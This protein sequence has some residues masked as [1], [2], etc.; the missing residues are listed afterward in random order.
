MD[1]LFLSVITAF[2]HIVEKNEILTIFDCRLIISEHPN[3]CSK[4]LA[5]LKSIS[6]G[7]TDFSTDSFIK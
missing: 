3:I 6:R 1:P 7:K 2:A 4:I 5:P